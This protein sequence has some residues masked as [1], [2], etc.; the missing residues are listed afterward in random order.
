M[1]RPFRAVPRGMIDK[2]KKLS[3]KAIANQFAL[4]KKP[5]P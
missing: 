4:F 2:K 5:K 3:K 1:K